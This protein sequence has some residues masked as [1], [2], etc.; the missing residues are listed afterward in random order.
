MG[1]AGKPGVMIYF[2]TARAVK[3]CSFE[4]KGR[5]FDAIL[6]YA[7]FGVVPDL[8]QPLDMAWAFIVDKLDRDNER[9]AEIQGKNRVKGLISDFKRNY[10]PAHGLDPDDKEALTRFIALRSQVNDGPPQLTAVDSGQPIQPTTSPT[11]S[12]TA[13]TTPTGTAAAAATPSTAAKNI[14]CLE[15]TEKKTVDMLYNDRRRE[16]IEKLNTYGG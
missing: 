16:A 12:P 3:R 4:E 9:Y 7:E 11:T 15:K 13:T 2:E 10:A 5:L 14:S 1:K 8:P 6:E